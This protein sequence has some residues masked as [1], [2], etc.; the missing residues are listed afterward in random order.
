MRKA[1]ALLA[2]TLAIMTSAFAAEAQPFIKML[3]H[4]TTVDLAATYFTKH[5]ATANYN[6]A[7]PQSA[8]ATQP[9]YY[10]ENQILAVIG[11][12]NVKDKNTPVEISAN[13]VSGEWAYILDD[14]YKRP[15]G[16]DLFARG[17]Y[18]VAGEDRDVPGYS[19][20][21]GIQPNLGT[22]AST[23]SI[24]TSI[25]KDYDAIWWDVCLVMEP[26]V[27]TQTNKVQAS[28]GQ[29][30]NLTP[31][32][33]Y[34]TAILQ[35]TIKC[36][37]ISETFDIYL[38]GYYK[39]D[40]ISTDPDTTS[41]IMTVSKLSTANTLDI[42]EMISS[43]T[44]QPVATYGFTSTVKYDGDTSGTVSLFLSSAS[45]GMAAAPGEFTL[46]H[47]GTNGSVSYRDTVHNSVPF[48]AIITST[49]GTKANAGSTNSVT[50]DGTDY[51][52]NPNTPNNYL[53]VPAQTT[54]DQD[55][56]TLTR[57]A[58]NGEILVTIPSTRS[59]GSAINVDGL[60]AGQYTSDIYVHVVTDRI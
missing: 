12:D 48:N 11:I 29:T 20:H 22:G 6:G 41:I 2:L 23:T 27:D 43:G 9:S 54:Y 26:E 17:S 59:D 34:Y 44:S 13:L 60:V 52:G 53:V 51:F 31:T 49:K 21:F 55:N 39:S 4:C 1:I 36:G 30:Y 15:F 58:D 18:T 42:A 3:S 19:L 14:R 32:D 25:A 50:Y 24:P 28:D 16:I 46:R 38:Q 56:R 33:S 47:I 10:Y 37:E 57:W 8:G 7:E 5:N 45:N 35:V 40:N